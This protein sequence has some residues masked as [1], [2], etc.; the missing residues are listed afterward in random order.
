MDIDTII[1]WGVALPSY[2]KMEST[3][4]VIVDMQPF[5]YS[6]ATIGYEAHSEWGDGGREILEASLVTKIIVH[7]PKMYNIIFVIY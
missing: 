5:S 3:I 1:N 6:L 2:T 4:E 7:A